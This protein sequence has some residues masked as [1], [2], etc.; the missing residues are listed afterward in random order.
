MFL[1][2]AE[3]GHELRYYSEHR[4]SLV[5]FA[6]WANVLAKKPDRRYQYTDTTRVFYP[7]LVLLKQ[8]KTNFVLNNELND[9]ILLHR[10]IMQRVY[11]FHNCAKQN[12]EDK[13]PLDLS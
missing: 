6:N 1:V 8:D 2:A 4:Q 12:P 7:L 13:F 10:D 9:R 3:Q 5:A 11:E